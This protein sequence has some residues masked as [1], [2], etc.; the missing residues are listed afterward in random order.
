MARTS[1]TRESRLRGRPKAELVLTAEERGVLER[2]TNRRK[3]AQALALRAR[4]ILACAEKAQPSNQDVAQRLHV[5]QATVG[6]WRRRFVAERLDGLSDDPRP[7]APR[8]ITDDKVEAVIVKTLEE[9]PVDATHWSTRSMAQKVGL[10]PSSVGRIWRAFG[11]QPHR[12]ETFKLSTDPL[13][14]EKLRDVVGLY[15]DPPERAVVFCV[16]EKSQIQALNRS[17]PILPVL[18]GVPERR[19]HDYKR[20]GTTSLFAALDMATGKVIGSLHRRHRSVEFKKFLARLDTEVP[21]DLDVHL[22]CDNYA[23]HKTPAVKRWLERHPRFHLH[24]VPTSSS[25]LNMVERLFAELTNKKIRR[26]SHRSVPELERDI[27]NWI[28]TWNE[29]PRPYVWVKTADEILKSIARYLERLPGN[30]G[31]N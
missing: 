22:I 6:K 25:W 17:Q 5:N 2:L 1:P 15:L 13:F 24:F 11:L 27:R 16:D 14:I 9:T 31:T 26:G 8:K 18:P 10:S 30:S 19:S 20:N 7:G 21:D 12:Y 3:T 23:T 29:N 28:D 4:I